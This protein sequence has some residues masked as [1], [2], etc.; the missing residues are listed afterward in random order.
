MTMRPGPATRTADRPCADCLDPSVAG[1]ISAWR[2]SRPAAFWLIAY[3]FAITM[4]GTTLPTPLYVIYQ[5]QWHFATSLITLIFAVYAVGVLVAL[6]VAGRSSDQVGRRPVLA[7]AIG[8]SVLSA[9]TFILAPSVEWLFVGRVLSGLSAGLMTGTATAA[10]TETARSGSP[11]LASLVSTTANMGGLGL[12]PLL[13]GLLAQYAAEP[14]V[15]PFAV[16]LGLVAVAGVGLL[17]VP[18]TVSQRSRLSLRFRGLGIPQAGRAEFIAAGFAGFAAFSLLGLFSS[19]VPTFLGTVL[20]DT[21]HATA[22]AV[23]FLAFGLG[24]C[25][26]LAT[27]RLPSRRVI[28]AGLAIFLA[29]LALIVAGL[30]AASMPLFLVGTVVSGVAT[31]AVFMGSLAVANRLAPAE[32]RGQVIS[33]FF[34]FAYVGL[35]VPVIAVGFGSQ[36]FGDFSATLGCAIALAAI[37]LASMAIIRRSA[38]LVRVRGSRLKRVLAQIPP[39]SWAVV[40]GAGIVS[41][42]LQSAHQAALSAFML[43]LA[44]VAWLVLGVRLVCRR[45]QFVREAGS[46]AA[47][48]GVAGTAVLGTRLAMQD[49][50]TAAVALLA[51][52]AVWWALLITPVLRHWKTPTA[53]LSFVLSVA[54]EGLAVLAATLAVSCR[55][56]W[57]LTAAVTP[58]ILGLAFYAFT[59]ARFDLREIFDG[60]GDQWIAGGALAISALAAAT[61]AEAG[62]G[63]GQFSEQHSALSAGALVLW[64]LAM[65]W[66]P[67]LVTAELLRPRLGYDVRR[68]GTVFPLGMYA[69]CSFAT[70]RVTGITGIIEFGR[71][72][73]WIAFTASLLA[74]PHRPRCARRLPIRFRPPARRLE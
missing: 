32:T 9:V 59:A 11:R 17:I 23:V 54:T 1:V 43:W 40:M 37:A 2:L 44:A 16:Q 6:L 60:H 70:G 71:V 15:L 46:P 58:L 33:T 14:T 10:L 56:L 39:S 34:V 68:W 36:A 20:H 52:S 4:L 74:M 30:S 49:Y 72:W 28:L 47:F 8:L 50:H 69:A 21:S 18:E 48:T 25:T 63:L 35:T 27:S 26:Q 22:G 51:L 57:L 7:T 31:G 13:A 24:A 38:T 19:L 64:G 67:V 5:S 66:L 65:A 12:G 53:G 42:D 73:T 55:A 41:L 3:A 29:A 62:G 45:D 61:V